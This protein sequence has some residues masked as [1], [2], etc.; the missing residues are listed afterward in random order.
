MRGNSHAR[1][2]LAIAVLVPLVAAVAILGFLHVT[3]PR[4][5]AGGSDD[6]FTHLHT[7]KAMA[8][9]TV[10]PGRAGPLTITVELE[11]PDERPLAA[12]AVSVTLSKPDAGVEPSTAQAQRTNDG[13]WRADMTAPVA[14][15]WSLKLGIQA[16]DSD[17]LSV[18]APIV[19]K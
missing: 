11:T 7:E 1:L 19:I 15:R 13:R 17:N 2:L 8:N 12:N 9:V 14:G 16:A 10:F 18:E 3:P 5:V 4:M 6:F